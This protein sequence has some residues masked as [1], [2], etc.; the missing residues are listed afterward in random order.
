LTKIERLY[1]VKSACWHNWD[2][3]RALR[4]KIALANIVVYVESNR[5]IL[6]RDDARRNEAINSI[7]HNEMLLRE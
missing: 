2:Y 1:G 7:K 6:D 3:D 4:F 5:K